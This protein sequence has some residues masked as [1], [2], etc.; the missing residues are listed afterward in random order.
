MRGFLCLLALLAVVCAACPGSLVSY[1]PF[2][3]GALDVVGT[4]NGVN[5][6]AVSVAGK[7]GNAFSFDGVDDY[8]SVADA[9]SLDFGSGSFSVSAWVYTDAALSDVVGDVVSKFDPVAKKGFNFNVLSNTGGPQS[10]YRN[11]QFGINDN[12]QDTAW[13][14]KAP[15]VG[16][17][18]PLAVFNGKLYGGA[19]ETGKLYEWNG[20][21]AWVEKA[22]KL[23]L[24]DETEVSS[25]AVFNGKLYGTTAGGGKLV[26]WNGVN[27]WAQKAPMLGTET[28]LPSLAVFN[29]KLYGGTG[30][31]GR[32][33]EWNG[34]D[35]WA[36][37]AP[38][39]GSET[40]IS[41]LAVFNGKLYGGTYPGGK[42]YEWTGSAWVERAPQLNGQVDIRSLAVFNGKL[43]GSAWGGG[44]LFEWNGV[45]A[46]VEKAP[47]LGSEIIILSLAV[48]NGKLYGSTGTSGGKLYEWNDNNAW[49]EKA[50]LMG[51]ETY[52][53]SL[54][55][56]NG[57]LYASALLGGNLFEWKSGVAVSQNSELGSGW[58]HLAAVRD[59]GVLRLYV[60]GVL[61]G[62]SSAFVAGDYDLSN[63][64]ALLI[65]FGAQDYF[66]GRIDDLA[67]FNTALSQ[68]NITAVYNG[69]LA[70]NG[71]CASLGPATGSLSA[72]ITAPSVDGNAARNGFFT[73]TA[74][75]TCTDGP[76]GN[77]TAT[78]DPE[79]VAEPAADWLTQLIKFVEELLK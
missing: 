19:G 55:V 62:T 28:T 61:V 74:N 45:D 32:L 20:V 54:A 12:K 26:E 30:T 73:V 9:N 6:G 77:V 37:K 35:A 56:F 14:E 7:A 46:W 18:L 78:L 5:H 67:V 24:G 58:R 36:Q 57:K 2:D 76:C 29:G 38:M 4:N 31:N 69:G 16:Q 1:W 59:G 66:N 34:V 64:Q 72:S 40:H 25:L 27:A 75:I 53:Y 63:A 13:A 50:P 44:R 41:S 42:L 22:P 23:A 21:D 71:V 70:G 11:T 43:Y 49:V 79:P 39:L 65:G 51:S 52:V 68:D 33:F 47:K 10:N 8:V 48:F 60:D 3:A 17:I 15:S